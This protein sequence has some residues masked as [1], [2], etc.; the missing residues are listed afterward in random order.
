M[1][2][3]NEQ[4]ILASGS[5][6]RQQ[7]LKQLSINFNIQPSNIDETPLEGELPGQ[8]VVRLGR[9]KCQNILNLQ[10]DSV[11]IAGDQ[12]LTFD[13]QIIGKPKTKENA[14]KQL[15]L[16]SGNWVSSLSNIT[17]GKGEKILQKTSECK[18]KYRTLNEATIDSYI[19][20]ESCLECAGSLRVESNG[21]LLIESIESDDPFSI[22]GMPM[23][24]TAELLEHHGL[25]KL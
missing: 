13:N 6:M 21:I 25:V 15:M 24:A 2:F 11:V 17:I 5:P 16:C 3:I 9:E 18:I 23:I 14:K 20:D 22:Y 10:P 8:L 1:E 4:Y 12:I 7:I 19:Q